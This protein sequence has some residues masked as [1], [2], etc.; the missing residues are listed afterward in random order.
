MPSKLDIPKLLALQVW[1]WVSGHTLSFFFIPL[2]RAHMAP[3]ICHGRA[4][5]PRRSPGGGTAKTEVGWLPSSEQVWRGEGE[6]NLSYLWAERVLLSDYR[7]DIHTKSM[8]RLSGFGV[9][10]EA[11]MLP[12]FALFS[13][14]DENRG[15]DAAQGQ[16]A[17]K[18]L[19]PALG[20]QPLPVHCTPV[21]GCDG[22]LL[23]CLKPLLPTHTHAHA[24]AVIPS[25]GTSPAK[26]LC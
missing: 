9:W 6:R 3:R 14:G 15:G 1:G 4:E 26:R 16:R 13:E 10:T 21:P 20:P 22:G 24:H 8:S 5:M 12:T 23:T 25:Q 17:G 18:H 19:S 7:G 11:F 2:S